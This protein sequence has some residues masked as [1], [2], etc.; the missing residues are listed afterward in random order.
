MLTIK[1]FIGSDDLSEVHHIREQ[2]F[3]KEQGVPYD[4]EIDGTDKYAQSV[5][6]LEDDVPVATGRI[7]LVDDNYKLGRISVLKEHRKKGLGKIVVDELTSRAKFMGADKVYI[8][9]QKQVSPFY[10]KLGFTS[11]G[12][13]F[14]EAGIIHT[15]MEKDV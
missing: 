8:H 12:N 15:S 3:V 7:I 1:W 10:E 13:E 14:K 9:A 6:I 2:V 4:V 5:L 11:H